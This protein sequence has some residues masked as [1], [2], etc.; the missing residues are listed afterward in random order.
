LSSRS[1]A[2]DIFTE[3]NLRPDF[4]AARD[5]FPDK[6]FYI[7]GSVTDK[8]FCAKT[9]EEISAKEGRFE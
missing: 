1:D 3:D 2:L 9:C 5:Y 6:L 4:K 8:A 7:S